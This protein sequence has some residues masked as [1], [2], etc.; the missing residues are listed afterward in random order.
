MAL[1]YHVIA[2]LGK[3]CVFR[4]TRQDPLAISFWA[5]LGSSVHPAPKLKI[6]YNISKFQYL[7]FKVGT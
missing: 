5:C 1:N 7:L 4:G 6:A 2:L 3:G